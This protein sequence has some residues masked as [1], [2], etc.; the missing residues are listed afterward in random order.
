VISEIRTYL[1]DQGSAPLSDLARRFDMDEDA[2][3]GML[4]LW[5][6]KGLITIHAPAESCDG[7]TACDVR[8]QEICE[9]IGETRNDTHDRGAPTC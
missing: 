6:R 3:R 2:V 1:R 4:D 8:F 5:V 9:W 7:C